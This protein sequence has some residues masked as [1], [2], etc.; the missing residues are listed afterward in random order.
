MLPLI[1]ASACWA[2]A[3]AASHQAES[4]AAYRCPA[5][6][7]SPCPAL[8]PRHLAAP[9]RPSLRREALQ[10]AGDAIS[11][12]L[13]APDRP[14]PERFE[15]LLTT[16]PVRAALRNVPEP[17]LVGPALGYVENKLSQMILAHVVCTQGDPPSPA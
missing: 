1:T 8:A 4:R 5:R 9:V 6:A 10:R 12:P 14:P 7:R 3:L 13:Q 2:S 11:H 17:I 16:W 15:S